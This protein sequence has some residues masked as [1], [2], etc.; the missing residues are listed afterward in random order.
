[1][2]S[3]RSDR[4][5]GPFDHAHAGAQSGIGSAAPP[6]LSRDRPRPGDLRR[7]AP[8]PGCVRRTQ[9][10]ESPPPPPGHRGRVVAQARMGKYTRAR[11]FTDSTAEVHLIRPGTPPRHPVVSPRG[12]DRIDDPPAFF[13]GVPR[14]D[15]VGSSM[16]SRIACPVIGR[17]PTVPVRV[18][19]TSAAAAGSGRSAGSACGAIASIRSG[20]R[21]RARGI[22]ASST[23][24]PRQ[25]DPRPTP[26]TWGAP[27]P[28]RGHDR[29]LDQGPVWVGAPHTSR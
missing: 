18:R 20:E 7:T 2:T 13:G 16:I 22:R 9:V 21:L 26:L 19:C 14:T 15:S 27:N 24:T 4:R 23:R 28:P 11:S 6:V 25:L 12:E 5:T 29:C 10:I 8:T 3:T 17:S 1:M